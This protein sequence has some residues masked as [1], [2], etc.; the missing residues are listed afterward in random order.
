MAAL[1]VDR[2]VDFGRCRPARRLPTSTVSAPPP[3]PGGSSRS[4][5]SRQHG[6]VENNWIG[7]TVAIGEPV[8]LRVTGPCPRCVMTALRK[9]TSRRTPGILRTAAQHNN[10]NVDVYADVIAGGRFVAETRSSLR[11]SGDNSQRK[12]DLP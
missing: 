2:T 1:K 4:V 6:F 10:V 5:T 9:A 12:P 3:P 11:A 8:R 7:H